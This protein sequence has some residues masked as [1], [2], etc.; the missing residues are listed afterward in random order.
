MLARREHDRWSA[1]RLL[2]GW[3]PGPRNN[4]LMTHPNL[5]SWEELTEDEQNRDVAQVKSAID[6]GRL[7]VRQGFVRRA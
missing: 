1:E 2:A 7:L 6:V 3:R 5:K 4:E